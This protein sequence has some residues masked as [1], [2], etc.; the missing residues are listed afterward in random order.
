MLKQSIPLRSMALVDEDDD[1]DDD[2]DNDDGDDNSSP[3]S[4]VNGAGCPRDPTSHATTA[5]ECHQDTINH[6]KDLCTRSTS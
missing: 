6:R 3:T 4:G 1:N 5:K 2:G